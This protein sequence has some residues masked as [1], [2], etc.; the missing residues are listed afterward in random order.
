MKYDKLTNKKSMAK[1]LRIDWK[2][3]KHI[4]KQYSEEGLRYSEIQKNLKDNYGI[5]VSD[6]TIL[7][8]FKSLG[9]KYKYSR[10]KKDWKNSEIEELRVYLD[11]KL[12][13]SEL[14]QLFLNRHS[15]DSI[16]GLIKYR[17][18]S[19][20]LKYQG[21]KRFSFTDSVLE[22]VYSNIATF[23]SSIP[24]ES[25]RLKV[26]ESHLRNA[27]KR[28]Y[29]K[30]KYSKLLDLIH[31]R[32]HFDISK[33]TLDYLFNI[34][35]LSDRQIADKFNVSKDI[36]SH[37]RRKFGIKKKPVL[38]NVEVSL[39]DKYK[40][41]YE[42]V[43]N[44]LNGKEPT[45]EILKKNY[46]E[47]FSKEY[48]EKLLSENEY[49]TKKVAKKLGLSISLIGN[50]RRKY[51]IKS[52]DTSPKL[53]DFPDEFYYKLYVI[54][55][56]SYED[57][58]EITKL[59]SSTIRKY[60]NKR[61]NKDSLVIKRTS[62]ERVVKNSLELL[63]MI[64][65]KEQAYYKNIAKD[66]REKGIFIDFEV[67]YND[68]LYWIEYNGSQHYNFKDLKSV[69]K[70]NLGIDSFISLLNRDRCLRL[71]AKENNITLIEIP[72]TIRTISKVSKI[73][74]RII[75]DGEIPE[76]VIDLTD[77]FKTIKEYGVNPI[78]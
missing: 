60:I 76:K 45:E 49:S 14:E 69:S 55:G 64:D 6:Q 23:N 21:N 25:E 63:G 30:E 5:Q 42:I 26:N 78:E 51:N 7:E 29:G 31:K 33:E 20:G 11:K 16:K 48:L 67:K 57:I 37:K 73:L 52:V 59:S 44:F 1:C 75:I 65:F 18:D 38:R 9:I 68:K 24:K 19:L 32:D 43:K 39:K 70:N 13:Y 72:F 53:K 35:E 62:G 27:L 10:E 28:K 2:Q 54:D 4:L 71:Y 56:F 61:F 12:S 74:K 22:E 40:G 3:Y 66:Y 58:S 36:I 41:K 77:F 17:G 46:F 15:I 8:V 50:L 47:I 34:E